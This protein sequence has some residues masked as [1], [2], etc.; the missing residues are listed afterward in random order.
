MD[1]ESKELCTM[2]IMFP[3]ESDDKAVQA[4]KQVTEALKDI[5]D[6]QIHFALMP[7][8]RQSNGR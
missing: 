4:K 6:V 3:V 8:P 7:T 1:S 2:R 5:E